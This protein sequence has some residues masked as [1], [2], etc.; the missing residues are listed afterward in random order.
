MHVV[1]QVETKE[2]L[3]TTSL[4]FYV[5]VPV[6]LF[7]VI[8]EVHLIIIMT[9]VLSWYCHGIEVKSLPN[10]N[11]HKHVVWILRF[12]YALCTCYLHALAL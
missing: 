7:F 4:P 12:Q 11:Y 9:I 6:E 3:L 1:I 10:T 8:I 5:H 2:N